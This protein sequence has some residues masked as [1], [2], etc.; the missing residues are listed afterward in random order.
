MFLQGKPQQLSLFPPPQKEVTYL[1]QDGG[2]TSS[3]WGCPY[4]LTLMGLP[5]QSIT[6]VLP[7]EHPD[8]YKSVAMAE[9]YFG[10][11]TIRLYQDM[12]PIDVFFKVGF[13][14]NSRIDPCSRVLKREPLKKYIQENFDPETTV[15]VFGITG[16]EVRRIPSIERNWGLNGYKTYFPLRDIMWTVDEWNQWVLDLT[17]FLPE[18]YRQGYHHLNCKGACVNGGKAHWLLTL[19][20]Q[21]RT[22]KEWEEGEIAF[23]EEYARKHPEFTGEPYTML[24]EVIDGV[25]HRLSLRELRER[26]QGIK[27]RS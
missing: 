7:N 19:K 9:Q 15:L 20:E 12:D 26:E 17:G 3:N 27:K 24:K 16:T 11:E 22:Y 5:W 6:S 21:P 8:L 4:A 25:T 23:Q 1:I 13:W 10:K 18:M 2:G 14:G